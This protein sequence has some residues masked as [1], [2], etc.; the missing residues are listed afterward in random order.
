MK[1]LLGVLA[2]AGAAATLGFSAL[3]VADV[4]AAEP[5]TPP[6]GFD[7]AGR[8]TSVTPGNDFYAYANGDY[9]KKLVIPADRSRYGSF[10]AVAALSQQRVHDV[11]ES[12]AADTDATGAR[13]KIGAFYRAFMD[14]KR[15]D[16]LG[17]KPLAPELAAIRAADTRAALARLMGR[18]AESF[19][20]GVFSPSIRVDEN[21]PAHYAV[22]LG[23]AGLGLPDRD[24]Y[25]E[26][27]F[28]AQ[29][30]AYQAYVA[31]MLKLVD[32][33][34]ADA[35]AKAIVDMETQIAAASWTM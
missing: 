5:Q 29:K 11:L 31:Q 18:G 17:A 30:A 13:A 34:D 32:W 23:Q 4:P 28:A 8:D 6:W 1:R 9:V 33:P 16:A 14:E 27:S 25:L 24:Y 21:D 15:V 2:A 26:P 7:L 12:A 10:D 3:S 22:Y 20:G 35:Q 19:Y